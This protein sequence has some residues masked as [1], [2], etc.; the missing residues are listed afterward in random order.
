MP[1]WPSRE[2]HDPTTH[3]TRPVGPTLPVGTAPTLPEGA[4]AILLPLARAAIAA[5]LG[6]P[7]VSPQEPPWLAEPGA[8]FVTLETAG[9]LH[10]CIGTVWA[11]RA[12]GEDV[13]ANA[14]A[15]AVEDRRFAPLSPAELEDTVVEVSV[16]SPTSGVPSDTEA[17]A[18]SALR[19]GV[20]GVVF[21]CGGRRATLLPQV[22]A[23]LPE[24]REF[25]AHLRVKAGFPST[26]WS[27]QVRVSR[28]TVTEFHERG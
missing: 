8:C 14:A 25:L 4:G 26:F 28:Y 1:R 16:L 3:P 19:P 2:R 5:R 20:D 15:A 21:E 23:T 17:E 13:R 6:V 9:R 11:R 22:W 24:P 18:L 27:D 7:T 10:G 12:L